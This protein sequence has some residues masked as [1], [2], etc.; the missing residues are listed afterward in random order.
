MVSPSPLFLRAASRR[1]PAK[2]RLNRR[3]SALMALRTGAG[4]FDAC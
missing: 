4:V 3:H 1:F 2:T